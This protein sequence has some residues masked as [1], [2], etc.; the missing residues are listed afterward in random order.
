VKRST[1]SKKKKR[2]QVLVKFTPAIDCGCSPYRLQNS[3]GREISLPNDFLDALCTRG[4]ATGSLRTYSYSLLCL[5]T[6]LEDEKLELANLTE[7][8]LYRYIRF[9]RPRKSNESKLA[10]ATINR[11]LTVAR[12]LYR[13]QTGD[14]LP[15]GRGTT[16]LPP[17]L[18]QRG[19]SSAPGY[20]YP[21]RQ[22][23]RQLRVSVPRRAVVP[24]AREEIEEFLN[25]LRT[26]RDLAMAALML[27]CGLRSGEVLSLTFSGLNLTEAQLLVRGK[28][29]KERIVPLPPEA[30]SAIKAYLAGE[31]PETEADEVFV[32]LKG[33][34]RGCPMTPAGFRTIFRYHRRR[35]KVHKANPHR[36]RHTF[37]SD[38]VRGGISLPALMHL[39]GHSKIHTTMLYVNLAP[40]E[41]WEEFQRVTRKIR[42]ERGSLKPPKK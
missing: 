8:D 21:C 14:D 2:K 18:Y 33:K 19:P 1:K 24:L 16:K 38:M 22:R 23:R 30:I 36:F 11:H 9:L 13:Y 40:R 7:A 39:M 29:N 10:A 12:S 32:S 37:G 41:V 26:W 5:W 20:L 34:R 4:L 42:H 25:S 3:E 31:R 17:Q 28:G 6:W 15:T 27:L 35:S